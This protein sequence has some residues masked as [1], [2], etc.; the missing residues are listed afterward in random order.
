[1]KAKK[2]PIKILRIILFT[3]LTSRLA[4]AEAFASSA[5][6]GASSSLSKVNEYSEMPEGG[7]EEPFKYKI[8]IIS[9]NLYLNSF[10]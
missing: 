5:F 7:L 9:L 10:D 8:S 2:K 6:R 1:M 4:T 3:F